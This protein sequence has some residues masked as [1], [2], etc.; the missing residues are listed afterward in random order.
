V[1]GEAG[2]ER[3]ACGVYGALEERLIAKTLAY[4]ATGTEGWNPL[5]STTQSAI[6]AAFRELI[7]IRAYACICDRAR[8]RSALGSSQSRKFLPQAL[9]AVPEMKCDLSWETVTASGSGSNERA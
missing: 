3:A 7:E 4:W 1:S 5:L 2:G 9:K 6:F 8:T